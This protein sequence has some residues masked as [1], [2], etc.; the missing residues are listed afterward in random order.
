MAAFFRIKKSTTT[1][2]N[3]LKNT[4]TY[5]ITEGSLYFS[6]D[7]YLAYDYKDGSTLKRAVVNAAYADTAGALTNTLSIAKGGTGAVDAENA[8]NN[9]GVPPKNHAATTTEYGISTLTNY[10]HSKL[11]SG[12]LGELETTPTY[13]DGVAAAAAHT[14]KKELF[15]VT[16]TLTNISSGTA[17]KTGNEIKAAID[18]GKVPVVYCNW[19]G[20][21]M[22]AFLSDCLAADENQYTAVFIYHN[23]SG[24]TPGINIYQATMRVQYNGSVT[25][26]FVYSQFATEQYVDNSIS[27]AINDIYIPGTNDYIAKDIGQAKGDI[28]Y[29]TGSAWTRLAKPT[30]S[31]THFLTMTSA[32][33]PAWATLPGYDGSYT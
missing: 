3:A 8:R 25:L 30:T 7:H 18:D 23:E 20:A 6:S 17:N 22:F 19:Q 26:S 29:Y 28:L 4:T 14:H 9:L 12:N 15:L 11:V 24:N 27:D 31:A 1:N 13:A 21:D 10:G 33:D 5:P 32:G 16:I 2:M